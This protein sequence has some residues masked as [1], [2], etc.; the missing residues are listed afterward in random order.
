MPKSITAK[1]LL[2]KHVGSSD[3]VLLVNPPV[4]ETR[5]SWLRWNQPLDLLKIGRFLARERGCAVNL[6]DF[7]LPDRKGRVRKRA[8]SG[9]ERHHHVGQDEYLCDYSMW[10]FGKHPNALLDW[11]AD[12]RPRNQALPTQV[13]ITSL[14][15]YWFP[16]IHQLCRELRTW[17]PDAEIVVLGNYPR[18][19]LQH[20]LDFCDADYIVS[21]SFELDDEITSFTLYG[22]ARP[23]FVSVT[24]NPQT[25]IE[26]IR[27]AARNEINRIAVFDDK[28]CREDGEALKEIVRETEELHPQLRFNAICGLDPSDVTPDQ[29]RLFAERFS[30]LHFEYLDDGASGVAIE[31]YGRARAYLE[32]AGIDLVSGK[33]T[34]GFV[35]IGRPGETLDGIIRNALI[36]LD[37]FGSVILK[38]FTPVPGTQVYEEHES[39]LE[40]IP[41]I[42]LSPHRFPFAEH[43]GITREEYHDLYRMAAF[44]NEKVKG[45]SFDLLNG[46]LGASLLRDSL[47]REVW[48]FG[49]ATLSITD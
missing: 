4:H 10:S 22:D 37:T 15:S 24:L 7:M 12:R 42:D 27:E 18:F 40:Q 39:Y 46:S 43:N 19:L 23:P 21:K 13:W 35:W 1:T 14:C 29:A 2:S 44:L 5:Y 25:A 9:I 16:S 38:P 31:V 33:S 28:I 49:S 48:N 45:R 6:F 3:H 36:V 20:A 47:R 41:H 34:G 17:L 26:T 8:L 32:E 11:V 30:E